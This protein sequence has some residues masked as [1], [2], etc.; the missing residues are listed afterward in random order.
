MMSDILNIYFV[1]KLRLLRKERDQIEDQ[2]HHLKWSIEYVFFFYIF[3]SLENLSLLMY[4][5]THI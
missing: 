3:I 1:Q 2:T 4:L 5:H